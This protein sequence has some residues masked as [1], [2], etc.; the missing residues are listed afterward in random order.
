MKIP[1]NSCIVHG[2]CHAYNLATFV[3]AAFQFH[4]PPPSVLEILLRNS[5][6]FRPVNPSQGWLNL[7]K[8]K[9]IDTDEWFPVLNRNLTL[10]RNLPSVTVVVCRPE[11]LN[12]SLTLNRNLPSVPLSPGRSGNGKIQPNQSKLSQALFCW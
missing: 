5:S 9:N 12:H 6:V 2:P 11:F 10:N 1:V 3:T 8:P 4:S 7:I